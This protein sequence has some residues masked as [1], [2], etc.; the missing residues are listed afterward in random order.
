M[1]EK[2][3][4]KVELIDGQGLRNRPITRSLEVS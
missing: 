2:I 4:E 1:I 3:K